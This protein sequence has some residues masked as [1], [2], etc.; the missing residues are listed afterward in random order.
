M[1]IPVAEAI[2]D[3]TARADQVVD[4]AQTR[5]IPIDRPPLQLTPEL[6]LSDDQWLAAH[7]IDV[8]KR[9]KNPALYKEEALLYREISAARQAFKDQTKR[10]LAQSRRSHA[11][12][13]F[14]AVTRVV[15]VEHPRNWLVC[16]RCQGSG[17]IATV[18]DCETCKGFGYL[19]QFQ[20][21]RK[22]V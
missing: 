3:I 7:C 20:P 16:G 22:G 1:N 5:S 2:A 9:M 21:G 10:A 17:Q 19:L 14:Y 13:F 4:H 12:P 8:I 18:G 6:E 11:G 15:N